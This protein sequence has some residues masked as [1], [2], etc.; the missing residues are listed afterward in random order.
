MNQELTGTAVAACCQDES[1]LE[2]QAN[3]HPDLRGRD[4]KLS[5]RVCRLCHKRHF[6][7]AL[8]PVHVGANLQPL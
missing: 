7:L 4:P 2:L 1:N 6:E 5:L 3:D 8:D